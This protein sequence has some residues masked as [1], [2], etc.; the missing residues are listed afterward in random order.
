MIYEPERPS[1]RLAHEILETMWDLEDL[2]RQL[3]NHIQELVKEEGHA[4]LANPS[5]S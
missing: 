5:R 4:N 1:S 3:I 2:H